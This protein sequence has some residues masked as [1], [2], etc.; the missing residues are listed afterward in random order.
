MASKKRK[1]NDQIA[2]AHEALA[3]TPKKHI[4]LV[5]GTYDEGFEQ[6]FSLL[7]RAESRIRVAE[8]LLNNYNN[9][10]TVKI[11]LSNMNGFL[12]REGREDDDEEQF[13][14]RDRFNAQQLLDFIDNSY[15]D[16]DSSMGVKVCQ[17]E[18][19]QEI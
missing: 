8:W 11:L 3:E 12:D 16:G 4:F 6:S 7:L 9:N 5:C 1:L 14:P 15:P 10:H 19:P 2:A 18:E 17:Y 13:E